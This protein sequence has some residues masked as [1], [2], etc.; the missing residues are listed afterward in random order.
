MQLAAQ[1]EKY[2]DAVIDSSK[3][4]YDPSLQCESVLMFYSMILDLPSERAGP[5]LR[6]I[7]AGS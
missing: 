3:V 7:M 5:V 2:L 4:S 6:Y 1:G